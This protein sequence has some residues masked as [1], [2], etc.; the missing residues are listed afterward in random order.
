MGEAGKI[1]NITD[2]LSN[3][4][5]V[6]E[7]RVYID[8]YELGDW[9]DDIGWT[10]GW[11]PDIIRYTGYQPG[12]DIVQ[13]VG[14]QR[15]ERGFGYHFGASHPGQ[16]NAVFADGHVTQIDYD[17]DLVVFNKL[18]DREDGLVVGDF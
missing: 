13:P 14:R 9:H 16:F 2:G 18:G 10:D 1:K 3:T 5:V 6:G 7:K 17:I 15:E 4:M 11:D 8:R 12:P